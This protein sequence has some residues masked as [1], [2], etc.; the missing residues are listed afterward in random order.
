MKRILFYFLLVVSLSVF[1]QQQSERA[2]EPKTQTERTTNTEPDNADE[3]ADE[4]SEA[5]PGDTD[6]KPKE[7]I[8]EDFPVSLPSDI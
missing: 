8:S 6:F 5:K 4:S 7:E 2:E 1:A 3:G